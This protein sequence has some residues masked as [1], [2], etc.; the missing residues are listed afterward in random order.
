MS[1]EESKENH[2]KKDFIKT[3]IS[4]HFGE[5]VEN[6]I[7]ATSDALKAFY[8]FKGFHFESEEETFILPDNLKNN[9]QSNRNK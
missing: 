6:E 8:K 7:L 2:E 5:S 1:W 4:T 9:N 3:Y